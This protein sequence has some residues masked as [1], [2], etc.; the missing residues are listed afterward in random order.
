ML[1]LIYNSDETLVASESSPHSKTPSQWHNIALRNPSIK[2][3]ARDG[4][5]MLVLYFLEG[6][7]EWLVR[8]AHAGIPESQYKLAR[9]YETGGGVFFNS[10][11]RYREIRKWLLAAASENHVPAMRLLIKDLK[12][13][14][15]LE[16]MEWARNAIRI[17]DLNT[18]YEYYQVDMGEEDR[19]VSSYGLLSL[20]AD[21]DVAAGIAE[22]TTE[23]MAKL[24]K[25]MT[26]Q[27]I[28]AGKAFAEEWKKTHPPLSRFLPKYGY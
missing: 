22:K 25:K 28:S 2:A 21:S 19:A 4:E 7:L 18:T 8:S 17:G 16:A 5:A 11:A 23:K 20:I 6:N 12:D 15:H 10:S 26:P 24:R 27:Q 9:V 14:Q 13:Y 3:R 1:R